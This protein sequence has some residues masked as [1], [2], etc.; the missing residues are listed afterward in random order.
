MI[1]LS[2]YIELNER[3]PSSIKNIR[4][5][6]IYARLKGGE[7]N[8]NTDLNKLKN[9]T[10]EPTVTRIIRKSLKINNGKNKSLKDIKRKTALRINQ[11]LD[12]AQKN[13]SSKSTIKK[14]QERL[15]WA[16]NRI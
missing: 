16:V 10:S 15:R 6:L 8:N 12:K 9:F 2:E 14:N 5:T 11:E 13:G 7:I 4:K 3:V 1:L